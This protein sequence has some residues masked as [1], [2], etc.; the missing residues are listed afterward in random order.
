ML[1]VV[2]AA[3]AG[4][5]LACNCGGSGGTGGDGGSGG[6]GGT[7][8]DNVLLS[9]PLNYNGSI[10]GKVVTTQSTRT[11]TGT[12]AGQDVPPDIDTETTTV[13]FEDLEGNTLVDEDGEEIESVEL[14]ADGTYDAEGLPVGTDFTVCV[15][16]DG[17]GECE[18]ASC[19]NIPVDETGTAGAL[20]DA[21]VDPLTT[22]VLAKLKALMEA[23]GLDP[24]QL[25]I[26]PVALV[27]RITEAY[28]HLFEDAG[29]D[30]EITLEDIE[31]LSDEQL[32][33]L[34]D[35]VIPEL[36]QLGMDVVDGNLD[37]VEATDLQGVALGAAKVFL[38]AGFPIADSE[39]GIDLSELGTI[40]GVETTTLEALWGSKNSFA[41]EFV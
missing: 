14:N 20:D 4:V 25:E 6:D 21:Q 39:G 30:G 7:G 33:T 19:V 17:D 36:A 5:G 32:A 15:D 35:T 34:F 1:G 24:T 2:A 26:S 10:S 23:K 11:S 31:A 38:G 22:V 27:S 37:L 3:A 12:G 13:S 8:T 16:E 18:M 40:E 28:E 41:E 9:D 29:V